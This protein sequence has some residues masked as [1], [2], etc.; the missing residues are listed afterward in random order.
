MSERIEAQIERF[1]PGFKDLML[2]KSVMT[3]AQEELHNPNRRHR[4]RCSDDVAD[5]RPAGTA[6]EPIPHWHSRYVPVFVVDA[7]RA[8]RPWAMW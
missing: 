8:R 4:I 3:A 5:L 1:A 7:A 6:L 2:A